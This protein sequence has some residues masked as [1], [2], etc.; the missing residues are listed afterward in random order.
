VSRVVVVEYDSAW[1]RRFEEL[2]ALIWPAVSDIALSVEH[3]GSTSVPGL[4]AKPII[5]LDVIVPENRV[6]AAIAGLEGL[7]YEHK[8]DLGIPAREA[9]E[10]PPDL[11]AHHLY[12]C[13]VGS[14]A[15]RNHLAVRDHLRANPEAVRR[16]AELKRDLARRFPDDMARYV[17]GKTAF[18][19]RILR[20]AGLEDE[21][22]EEIEGM[23]GRP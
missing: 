13:P 19:V 9:F 10:A 2:R 4:A 16:Y 11:P 15:L 1:P 12:L 8:G 14:R 17:E 3:V 18:L 5:D 6:R 20:E 23:N 22:V 7:G 21:V